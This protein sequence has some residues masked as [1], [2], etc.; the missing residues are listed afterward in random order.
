MPFVQRNC[1][2]YEPKESEDER[3]VES[4]AVP[5]ELLTWPCQDG[6]LR[7]HGRPG[8]PLVAGRWLSGGPRACLARSSDSALPASLPAPYVTPS[9]GP[10]FSRTPG[11]SH[12]LP[13]HPIISSSPFRT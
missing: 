13:P 5:F 12:L 6:V 11:P 1:R 3:L 4:Q 10:E 9:K 7:G 2:R 8:R